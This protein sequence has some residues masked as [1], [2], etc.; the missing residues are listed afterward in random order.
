MQAEGSPEDPE[1]QIALLSALLETGS[2]DYAKEAVQH[3]E[4][5]C[6]KAPILQDQKSFD[7]YLAGLAIS[8]EGS[9][10][11]KLAEASQKRD[12]HLDTS[13]HPAEVPL[14]EKA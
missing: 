1:K 5:H 12:A 14:A 3:Y 10:V 6:F 2:K 13:S 7:L 11:Q 4:A 8:N 9:A